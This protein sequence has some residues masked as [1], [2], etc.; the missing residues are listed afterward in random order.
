MS[1]S[2]NAQDRPVE[3]LRTTRVGAWEAR[4]RADAR[5]IS[6]DHR[7]SKIRAMVHTLRRRVACISRRLRQIRGSPR[8]A[9]PW[10]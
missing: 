5:R 8:Q 10:P 7:W 1:P 2:A 9:Q 4:P 3:G 6:I